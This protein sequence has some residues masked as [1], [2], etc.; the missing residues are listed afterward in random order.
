MSIKK[1]NTERALS[2]LEQEPPG[3]IKVNT[4]LIREFDKTVS[5]IL[6]AR[7]EAGVLHNSFEWGAALYECVKQGDR[8]GL[9]PILENRGQWRYGVL[10]KEELRS[11]KN[12]A[13]CMIS[14]VVQSVISEKL[15][16][17]ELGYSISD[18]CIQLIEQSETKEEII[19]K[20][21]LS[22]LKFTDE[23]QKY[24]NVKYHYMVKRTKEYVYKHFH[25]ELT[26]EKIAK[27]LGVNSDYLSRVFKKAEGISL[28]RY[29]LQE[30]T[31][32]AKNLLRYSDYSILEISK[33]LGFSTQSHFTEVFKR[34]SD[35]TPQAF[36]NQYSELYKEEM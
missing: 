19:T 20:L 22:L 9:L 25:E 36:R 3:A 7:H 11:A 13:I 30:R 34:F 18:A 8:D 28:K 35:M 23:I 16:Y 5:E 4:E 10:A 15:I 27:A 26:V 12:G 6:F 32:R 21:Y 31:T 29:I 2:L 14:F 24:R 33:Y 1:D 17:S